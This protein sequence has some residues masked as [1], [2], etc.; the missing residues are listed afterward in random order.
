MLSSKSFYTFCSYLQ[1]L[2]SF[3][4]HFCVLCEEEFQL[5]A[6][7]CGY[8]VTLHHLLKRLFFP[9]VNDFDTLVKN[10]MTLDVQVYFRTLNSIPLVYTSVLLPIS[11]CFNYCSFLL[12]FEV[13]VYESSVLF[14]KI[15][16]A[17]CC[18]LQFQMNLRISCFI[19]WGK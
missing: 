7:P 15:I 9:S 16:L 19:S 17:I 11:H 14:F 13:G 18:P 4:I 2:Y 6:F 10:Q 1:V 5:Q 8:F 12:S 3:Q